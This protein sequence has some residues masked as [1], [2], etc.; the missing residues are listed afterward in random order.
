[1]R[2]IKKQNINVGNFLI[3]TGPALKEK[4]HSGIVDESS[5][6]SRTYN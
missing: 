3:E 6:F 4:R 5:D 1:M 2:I